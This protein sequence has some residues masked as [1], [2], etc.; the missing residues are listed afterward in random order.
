MLSMAAL[1]QHTEALPATP[2]CVTFSHG[3]KTVTSHLDGKLIVIKPSVSDHDNIIV[4]F[5]CGLCEYPMKQAQ[6]AEA[7]R[8]HGCCAMCLLHWRLHGIQP[9]KSSDLWREYVA[10]RHLAWR[11]SVTV[12][13]FK[14][15]NESRS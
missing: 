2:Q 3:D 9:D 5:I 14:D 15:T 12:S 10:R 1:S 13:G 4:P 7:Y 6:D 11:P 8:T